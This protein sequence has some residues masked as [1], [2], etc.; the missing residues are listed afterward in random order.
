MVLDPKNNW[1]QVELSFEEKEET[2]SLI[3][4]PEDYRP[5]ERP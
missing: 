2:E 3:A 4:L 1:I 5:A